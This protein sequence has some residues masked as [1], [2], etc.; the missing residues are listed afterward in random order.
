[1]DERRGAP[2]FSL[3]LPMRYRPTGDAHW[4]STTT[5]NVSASGVL[6]LAVEP[7]VPGRKLEVEILM[8]ESSAIKASRVLATS[9]VVRQSSET[10]WLLTAIHHLQSQ[11]QPIPEQ[12]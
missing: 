4:R 5:K 7:L 2:R 10:E 3:M 6:F 8:T 1:M 9:E 11:T 12:A